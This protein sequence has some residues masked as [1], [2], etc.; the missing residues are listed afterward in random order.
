MPDSIYPCVDLWRALVGKTGG[1]EAMSDEEALKAQAAIVQLN[2]D[3]MVE[4]ARADLAESGR[5]DACERLKAANQTL[6]C[7]TRRNIQARR[8]LRHLSKF[9]YAVQNSDLPD[10]DLKDL[11][12]AIY[13]MGSILEDEQDD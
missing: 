4:R 7:E 10:D 2:H 6:L 5:L 3:V 9:A 8:C 12:E 13:L 1:L 11:V